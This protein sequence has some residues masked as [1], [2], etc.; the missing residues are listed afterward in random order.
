MRLCQWAAV[1]HFSKM[2]RKTWTTVASR[3]IWRRGNEKQ[4]IRWWDHLENAQNIVEGYVF[5]W[6]KETATDVVCMC[7]RW[8][9]PETVVKGFW[10]WGEMEMQK[11][12]EQRGL[13]LLSCED[14]CWRT[15]TTAAFGCSLTHS[16]KGSLWVRYRRCA[17]NHVNLRI[18]LLKLGLLG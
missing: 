14:P 15:C 2:L 13:T 1:Q 10:P 5:C 3:K 7:G 4:T 8:G 18:L 16:A 9:W 12:S 11:M 17:S 6:N